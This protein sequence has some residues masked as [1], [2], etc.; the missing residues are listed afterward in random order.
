MRLMGKRTGLLALLCI[1]F[2]LC[3]VFFLFSYVK[4]A[5]AWAAHPINQH[6]YSGGKLRNGSRILDRDG[7]ILYTA[8]KDGV[9]Y[10]TDTGVRKALLH[11]T[12]DRDGNIAAS[13]PKQMPQRLSGWNAVSGVYSFSDKTPEIV[14]TL[15]AGL[16]R[17]ASQALGSYSGA[18]GI[19]NY[20][21]GDILCMVS[22]P[23]FDPASPPDV[24]ANPEKYDGVYVNRFLS[25]SFTPGSIFKLVTAAAAVEKLP[26][27][28][29]RTYTCTG[30][31][32][33]GDG[34]VTCMKNHGE[35][36]FVQIVS[37]SCNVVFSQLALELGA[38]AITTYAK[39]AGFGSRV[40]LD[41]IYVSPGSFSLEDAGEYE[42]A[43]S[44]VGQH[45]T[46][47]NPLNYLLYTAAI[48]RD[49]KALTPHIVK[50]SGI[51]LGGGTVINAAT[52]EALTEAMRYSVLN[53]YGEGG[54]SQ[55]SPCAKSGTAEVGSGKNP[56]AWFT[57]F[58]D[59]DE[60]PYAFIVIAENGGAGSQTAASIA[61]TV[62]K[63]A[64]KLIP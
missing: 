45:T 31:V 38:D 47:A 56:H 37:N 19:I 33:I 26:D 53:N 51:S 9:S 29:T 13:L 24:A 49:G 52:A 23:T 62:L 27:A 30:E 35:Q 46:L 55:Y 48:A 21:T 50:N 41:G 7:I 34:K 57:G 61:Y 2:L 5:S 17:T 58:L 64:V 18:V 40:D 16:C 42:I 59:S 12:G 15:D 63:E 8:S 22:T 32:E 39:K 6:L 20:K 11:V 1:A 36:S 3:M 14:T 4:D 60:M 43:W 25:S 28:R 10:S 54:L 44:G